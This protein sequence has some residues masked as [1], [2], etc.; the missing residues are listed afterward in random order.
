[1]TEFC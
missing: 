1:M